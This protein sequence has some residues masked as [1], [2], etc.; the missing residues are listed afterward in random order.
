MYSKNY[1]QAYM[2][3]PVSKFRKVPAQHVFWGYLVQVLLT[4]LTTFRPRL[5]IYELR[6]A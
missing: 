4:P 6:Q 2:V 1:I 3:H 5:Q